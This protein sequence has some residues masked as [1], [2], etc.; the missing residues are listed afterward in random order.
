MNEFSNRR[1]R[2]RNVKIYAN[3]ILKEASPDVLCVAG[4]W[5]D[6]RNDGL[7]S[8]LGGNRGTQLHVYPLQ[9]SSAPTN[10][11]KHGEGSTLP[12]LG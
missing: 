7:Q 5:A 4:E 11:K 2:E 3:D 8:N 12:F 6:L 9:V 1:S 10:T